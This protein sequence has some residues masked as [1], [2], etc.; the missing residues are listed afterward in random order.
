MVI[1]F[2]TSGCLLRHL[3]PSCKWRHKLTKVLPSCLIRCK[4][5]AGT[6]VCTIYVDCSEA[7]GAVLTKKVETGG[8]HLIHKDVYADT[9][10][11]QILAPLLLYGTSTF[12]TDHMA[13]ACTY[14][15]FVING[16]Y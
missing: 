5:Y 3:N 15:Y 11:C 4:K 14:K 7:K 2:G 9:M 1:L 6:A 13:Q 8:E 10:T 16:Q 12:T